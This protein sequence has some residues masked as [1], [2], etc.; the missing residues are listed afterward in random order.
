MPNFPSTRHCHIPLHCTTAS[1]ELDRA[2]NRACRV[3]DLVQLRI[4]AHSARQRH[5]TA[6]AHLLE[7]RIDSIKREIDLQRHEVQ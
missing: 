6:L 2:T 3:L 1:V 4:D 5:D 7:L